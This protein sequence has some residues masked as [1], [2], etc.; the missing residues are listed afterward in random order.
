MS[1]LCRKYVLK[2][3]KWKLKFGLKGLHYKNLMGM[4]RWIGSL[5]HDWLD[6]NGVAFSV[7]LLEW[8]P[9]FYIFF[10]E[11]DWVGIARITFA[12]KWP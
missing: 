3:F 1:E 8:G 5:F 11:S 7:E 6:H 2:F 12:Q 10:L 4:C 9:T